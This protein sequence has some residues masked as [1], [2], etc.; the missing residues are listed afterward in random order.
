MKPA[1]GIERIL[2]ISTRALL[3]ISALLVKPVIFPQLNANQSWPTETEMTKTTALK[4][5]AKLQTRYV[6]V[7]HTETTCDIGV[8]LQCSTQQMTGSH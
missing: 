5:H 6:R 1:R 3:H 4:L 8:T 7:D 2:R